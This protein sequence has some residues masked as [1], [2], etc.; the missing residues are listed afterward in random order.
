MNIEQHN[1]D[2]IKKEPRLGIGSF[3]FR[4]A[5]G[6]NGFTPPEPMTVIDFLVEARRLGFE[7]VQL[8]E[9]LRFSHCSRDELITIKEKA[10][11]LGLFIE[12]GMRNITEENLSKHL[13]IAEILSSRFLRVVLGAEFKPEENPAILEEKTIKRLQNILPH[14]KQAGI[15]IGI[16]NHFDLPIDS[17]VRIAET[18]NDEHVG[19]ILDTTN[20]LGFI[21]QPKKTL[22]I[23]QPYLR[24]IHLKD[25]TVSKVE[26]GYLITGAPLGEGWLHPEEL[27]QEALQHNPDISIILEMTIRRREGQK[28]EDIITWEKDAIEKSAKYLKTI[29]ERG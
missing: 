25:Y 2:R 7:G 29:I 6:F 9:N 12:I 24:S 10:Q 28:V 21:E 8:C 15:E 16:E 4:Y 23:F 1:T 14:C 26:A 22:Q 5:I 17:L 19:L 3:A 20:C 13:N 11:E 18:L 27:L